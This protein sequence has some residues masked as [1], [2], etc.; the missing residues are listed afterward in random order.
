[1]CALPQLAEGS[2]CVC[3][4][5]LVYLSSFSL[6]LHVALS[7]YSIDSPALADELRRPQWLLIA[8]CARVCVCLCVCA[9]SGL[10]AHVSHSSFL[11]CMA[12]GGVTWGGGLWIA[13]S[14]VVSTAF[15]IT[16][17]AASQCAMYLGLPLL[18]L[19]LFALPSHS[20]SSLLLLTPPLIAAINAPTH[21]PPPS[22]AFI[23]RTLHLF[24]CFSFR[25][26]HTPQGIIILSR[27]V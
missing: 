15:C 2:L 25:I 5:I 17:D 4:V 1:M 26:L 23:E 14:K 12:K 6:S 20:L 10:P 3:A 8:K 9:A 11:H 22:I 7:G 18:S 16:F 19:S 27:N 24:T 21:A 13:K